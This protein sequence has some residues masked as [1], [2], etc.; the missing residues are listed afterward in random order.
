MYRKTVSIRFSCK[1]IH[2]LNNLRKLQLY[3]LIAQIK[4]YNVFTIIN[5]I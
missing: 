4:F 5:F 2:K 1:K 3:I